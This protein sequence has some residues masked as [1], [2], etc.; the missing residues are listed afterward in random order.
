[1]K[2][3]YDDNRAEIDREVAEHEALARMNTPA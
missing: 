1:M 2:I 3:T